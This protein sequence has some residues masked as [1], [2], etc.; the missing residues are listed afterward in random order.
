MPHSNW[1]P[2]TLAAQKPKDATARPT[3]SC[4]CHTITTTIIIDPKS[5]IRLPNRNAMEYKRQTQLFCG[6][7]AFV[8]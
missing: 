3:K 1:K 4:R 8:V 5:Y 6:G 7:V 2:D